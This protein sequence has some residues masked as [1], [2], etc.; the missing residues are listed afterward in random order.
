MIC[1]VALATRKFC[2][3][4]PQLVWDCFYCRCPWGYTNKHWL[5]FVSVLHIYSLYIQFIL[6][7][8]SLKIGSMFVFS[9]RYSNVSVFWERSCV[10]LNE[11][12]PRESVNIFEI[13]RVVFRR[14][15]FLHLMDSISA[16]AK[17][18]VMKSAWKTELEFS[19]LLWTVNQPKL[20]RQLLISTRNISQLFLFRNCKH[21]LS[22]DLQ[23]CGF[24]FNIEYKKK[25][26][27]IFH[28]RKPS[29]V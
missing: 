8:N 27:Q 4:H 5:L 22:H 14:N 7:M 29:I 9:S 23:I 19:N 16:E 21:K 20:E 15:F 2:Q 25:R 6:D 26:F 28:T 24:A 17:S 3:W 11:T 18:T 13:V 10:C 12:F 1:W